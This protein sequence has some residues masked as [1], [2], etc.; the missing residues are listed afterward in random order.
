MSVANNIPVKGRTRTGSL[1]ARLPLVVGLGVEARTFGKLC[2]LEPRL[3]AL[4]HEARA[5]ELDPDVPAFCATMVFYDRFKPRIDAVLN[6]L[7]Q[8]RDAANVLPVPD[9]PQVAYRR[10]HR[11]L[12]RCRKCQCWSG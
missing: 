12:P 2:R 7:Y 9:A 5:V 4:Y 8:S 3:A 1:F 6:A 11:A 10:I